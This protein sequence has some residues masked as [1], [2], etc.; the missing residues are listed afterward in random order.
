MPWWQTRFLDNSLLAWAV[1]GGL[2]ALGL[3][4]FVNAKLFLIRYLRRVNERHPSAMT[5]LLLRLAEGTKLPLMFLVALWWAS[6]PLSL[7]M[8]SRI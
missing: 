2:L 4:A 5:A 6:I 7:L 8:R 1:S 3:L